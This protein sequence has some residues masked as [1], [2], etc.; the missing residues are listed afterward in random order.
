MSCS[1]QTCWYY[2]NGFNC[3]HQSRCMYNH[4]Y[5]KCLVTISSK[6]FE[7]C[8]YGINCKKK[9]NKI[10][11]LEIFKLIT[12]NLANTQELLKNQK[13]EIDSLQIN[14]NMQSYQ[15]ECFQKHYNI[16][17]SPNE[18]LHL[19]NAKNTLAEKDQEIAYLKS[20]KKT[21]ETQINKLVQ[22]NTDL[23]ITNDTL[24]LLYDCNKMI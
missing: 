4:N 6:T 13:N 24:Q 19:L 23:Q 16:S 3:K 11:N 14:N 18:T 15:I 2:S 7:L 17:S 12:Q 5:D 20:I 21:Y 22:K 10:H 8:P 9:C 1:T